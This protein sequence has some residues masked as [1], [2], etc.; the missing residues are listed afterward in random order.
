M[1]LSGDVR[2]AKIV[3]S[4]TYEIPVPDDWGTYEVEF[5]RNE[6][7]SC[8]SNMMDELRE[9]ERKIECLCGCVETKCLSVGEIEPDRGPIKRAT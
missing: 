2:Y 4:I 9:L 7:S 5:H 1:T 3:V 6:S 8:A